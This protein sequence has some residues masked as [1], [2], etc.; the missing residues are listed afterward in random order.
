MVKIAIRMTY[1]GYVMFAYMM[2]RNVV[3][4]VMIVG[5]AVVMINGK[6]Q[7]I[8]AFLAGAKTHFLQR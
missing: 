6:T 4:V 7:K 2:V 3:I 8:L 1:D 5:A